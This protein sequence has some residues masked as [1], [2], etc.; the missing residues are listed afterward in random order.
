MRLNF[1]LPTIVSKL[2]HASGEK[3]RP[4]NLTAKTFPWWGTEN[5]SALELPHPTPSAIPVPTV[6]HEP[7]GKTLSCRLCLKYMLDTT[8]NMY[9]LKNYIRPI[10]MSQVSLLSC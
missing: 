5:T 10:Y 4:A 8:K 7:E 9:Q 1:P 2:E 3:T 6:E